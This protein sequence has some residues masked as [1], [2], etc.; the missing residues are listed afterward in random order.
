MRFA[1]NIGI[2]AVTELTIWTLAGRQKAL[3]ESCVI[4]DCDGHARKPALPTPSGPSGS[5]TEKPI[6]L[7]RQSFGQVPFLDGG[8][9]SLESGAA[10]LHLARK[11]EG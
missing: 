7:D 9:R 8:L 2:A 5:T 10:L 4:S 3:V 1:L 11:S 6:N